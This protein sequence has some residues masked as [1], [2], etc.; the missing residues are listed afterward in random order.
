[1]KGSSGIRTAASVAAALCLVVGFAACSE[2]DPSIKTPPVR[3][4]AGFA[5]DRGPMSEKRRVMA[6]Y[7]RLQKAF[8]E[9]DAQTVCRS[10]GTD[11]DSLAYY[12]SLSADDRFAACERDVSRVWTQL[13]GG[14]VDWPAQRIRWVRVYDA[15]KARPFGGITVFRV[16]GNGYLRLQFVKRDGRWYSDFRVPDELVGLNGS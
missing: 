12:D 1:M 5:D 7:R 4:Y 6:L 3:P 16:H 13:D 11:V 15:G 8:F 14:K 2:E 10:F 9:G